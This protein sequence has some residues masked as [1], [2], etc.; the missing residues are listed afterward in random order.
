M[1]YEADFY[2]WTQ[3]QAAALRQASSARVNAPAMIDWEHIAEEL[4]IMGASQRSEIESRL[5][6]LLEHLLKLAFTRDRYSRNGWRRTVREQRDRIE[7]S[8]RQSPSLQ[9]YPASVLAKAYSKARRDFLDEYDVPDLA[10]TCPFDL[11]HEVLA[12]EWFPS[13]TS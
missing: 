9:T 12:D 13:E 2:A 10:K 3:A 8:I 11:E 6:V 7:I 4:E 1:D 5:K